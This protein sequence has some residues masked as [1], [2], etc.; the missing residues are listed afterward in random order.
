MK[1]FSFNSIIRKQ[2]PK[3]V[4]IKT[5]WKSCH[6]H[7]SISMVIGNGIAKKLFLPSKFFFLKKKEVEYLCSFC[8]QLWY[9]YHFATNTQFSNTYFLFIQSKASIG[10]PAKSYLNIRKHPSWFFKKRAA[11]KFLHTLNPGLSSFQ[12]YLKAFLGLLQKGCRQGFIR[13]IQMCIIW[14]KKLSIEF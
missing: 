8:A 1:K 11:R 7:L 9:Q 12:V 13:A 6:R 10:V 4:S 14:Y 3:V 5:I 2:Q